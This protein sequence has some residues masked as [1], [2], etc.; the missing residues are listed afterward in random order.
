MKKVLFVASVIGHLNAF[1]VPCIQHFKEKGYQVEAAAKL[2]DDIKVC[3]VQHNIDFERQPFRIKNIAAYKKL[4]KIIED[5]KYDMVHCH[6]P[7]AAI[8]TR[9][10]ARR[11]R[12]KGTR[13]I[14]TAHGFHFFKGAPL[15][16]W[17]VY[18]TA[19]WLCSFLTETLITINKEDFEFAKKHLHAKKIRYI[20]GIGV[21]TS[22]F[23]VPTDRE[24]K[25]KELGFDD[26]Q[27]VVLSIGELSVRKNHRVI[28]EAL[29]KINDKNVHYVIAGRGSKKEELE[30]LA[31]ELGVQD[32]VHLLG[33]RKDVV[34]LCRAAD[35]F[36]L[37]SLQ[38][39]LGMVTLEAMAGGLPCVASNVR[40]PIEIIEHGKNG[41]LCDCRSSDDFA[42]HIKS[43]I[44]AF[45]SIFN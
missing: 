37:P 6:T 12:N 21:D 20:T 7:V 15:K 16:N 26:G 19:E 43:L 4:K 1:H 24:A 44:D 29:A 34:D 13:V 42:K 14:Y 2:L 11:V 33:F 22:R 25:R 39:G 41:F 3:E 32:N 27:I 30:A 5:G 31:K 17:L 9:L 28:I 35:V 10:A 23:L 18:F 38:E 8:L 36:C 40:G 45:A